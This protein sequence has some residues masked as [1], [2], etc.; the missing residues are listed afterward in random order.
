[1]N[2]EEANEMLEMLEE[3]SR[4]MLRGTA[5]AI[6]QAM[7]KPDLAMTDEQAEQA[8]STLRSIADDCLA[9]SHVTAEEY[10][11]M[12]KWLNGRRLLWD[13]L[14]DVAR[15]Q[16][17]TDPKGGPPGG[18]EVSAAGR[19]TGRGLFHAKP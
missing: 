17:S 1:V 9:A 3:G 19:A 18:L 15:G 11:L 6:T 8:E 16:A 2:H 5:V 12:V 4:W 14:H 13:V 10:D 7:A